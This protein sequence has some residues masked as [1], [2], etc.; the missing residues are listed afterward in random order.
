M[1]KFLEIMLKKASQYYD[2]KN[3]YK[4]CAFYQTFFKQFF[5][6]S[7]IDYE[8]SSY[9]FSK[10]IFNYSNAFLN[11]LLSQSSIDNRS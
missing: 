6:L 7:Q 5:E 2:S 11:C 1:N 4:S 8:N 9:D 3:Y 10:D